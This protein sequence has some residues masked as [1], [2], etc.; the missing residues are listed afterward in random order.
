M[1]NAAEAGLF[2]L[3]TS[4]L[5]SILGRLQLRRSDMDRY[6]YLMERVGQ[7][8][9]RT[10]AVFQRTFNGLYMVRRGAPWRNAFYELFETQK[11]AGEQSFRHVLTAL[12][13]STGRI[14]ASFTSKLLA[15][16]DPNMPVY[17][18]WVRI[19]MTLRTR[20]GPASQRIPALCEDYAHIAAAYAGIIGQAGYRRIRA[21]FD[22]ALPD[23]RDLSDVKKIDLLLWQA[24][25]P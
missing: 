23:L 19:N 22:N 5:P 1:V 18:S 12:H 10:D 8:D 15:T 11:S 2:D 13:D 9:V 21:D 16:I 20:T 6:R 3:L 24:R 25:A 4:S 17:D 7:C 14:E